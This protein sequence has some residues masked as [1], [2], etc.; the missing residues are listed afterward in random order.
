MK[1]AE[2]TGPSARLVKMTATGSTPPRASTFAPIGFKFK[3][4]LHSKLAERARSLDRHVVCLNPVTNR[5]YK[6]CDEGVIRN[7]FRRSGRG[8]VAGLP[9]KAAAVVVLDSVEGLSAAI[10]SGQEISRRSTIAAPHETQFVSGTCLN[11]APSGR[12]AAC[13]A[14]SLS[15]VLGEREYHA[16][17]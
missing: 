9:V 7:Q 16:D 6:G 13:G 11:E 12:F 17:F 10:F 8:L 15:D 3:Y 5:K 2:T 1:N 14:L 4:C